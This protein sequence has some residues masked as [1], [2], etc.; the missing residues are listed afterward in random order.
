MINCF[1]Q[2]GVSIRNWFIARKWLFS[3]RSKSINFTIGSDSPV[4]LLISTCVLNSS[5]WIASLASSKVRLGCR[6]I[7]SCRSCNCLSVNHVFPSDPAFKCATALVKICGSSHCR[8]L[9]RIL[10]AGSEGM[11]CPWSIIAQP[12]DCSCCRKGCSTSVYS[13]MGCLCVF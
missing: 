9:L 10:L 7:C 3:G 8:K 1:T 11:S 4:A 13:D 5:F 12:S 2:P 6:R